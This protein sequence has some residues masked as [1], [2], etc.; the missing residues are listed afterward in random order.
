VECV[1]KNGTPAGEYHFF[2]TTIMVDAMIREKTTATWTPTLPGG[3]LWQPRLDLG[4]TFTFDKSRLGDKHIWVDPH[5]PTN[6]ALISDALYAALR[7][8]KIESFQESP[9]FAEI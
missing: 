4:E 1:W 7:E 9:L 8:A 3:G 6:A 5:M 2:F